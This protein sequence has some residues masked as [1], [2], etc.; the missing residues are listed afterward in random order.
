MSHASTQ[1]VLEFPTTYQHAKD[2]RKVRGDS[3]LQTKLSFVSNN[4]KGK[5]KAVKQTQ[6]RRLM[7]MAL[8][9]LGK[10]TDIF[11]A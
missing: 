2:K 8:A 7:E 6:E 11:F 9:K 1:S 4:T 3:L 5:G 10:F